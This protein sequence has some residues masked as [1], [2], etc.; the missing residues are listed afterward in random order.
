[1]DYRRTR[2]VRR[3]TEHDKK[4]SYQSC[5]F[6]SEPADFK[7]TETDFESGQGSTVLV[8]ERTRGSKLEG[9]YQ[10][11]KGIFLEQAD[12]TLT[13]LPAGKTTPTI[14][15]KRDIGRSEDANQPCCLK[16]AD[17]RLL[18]S[19]SER[20]NE[21]EQPHSSEDRNNTDESAEE[22]GSLTPEQ[23]ITAERER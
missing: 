20:Y 15:S 6:I 18:A 16:E 1:M 23:P 3:K 2:K 8:R 7:L 4:S 21:E 5:Q 22:I 12:H 10:K 14:L 17:R 13:F 9:S 19:R 11:R